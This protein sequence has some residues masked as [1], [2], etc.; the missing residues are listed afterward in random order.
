[1]VDRGRLFDISKDHGFVDGRN[2]RVQ[3]DFD[4]IELLP[5]DYTPGY[6]DVICQGGKENYDHG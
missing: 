5:S 6:W 1:M 4:Q 3:T 2:N